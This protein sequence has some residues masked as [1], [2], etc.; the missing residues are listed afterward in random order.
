[1]LQ[2]QD[3]STTKLV[4]LVLLT[5]TACM[6]APKGSGGGAG[7][8]D[9]APVADAAP[10]A[11]AAPIVPACPEGVLAPSGSCY[12]PSDPDLANG[13]NYAAATLACAEQGAHLA[14]IRT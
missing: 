1:M 5:A 13:A 9:A 3:M 12:F 11:D 6:D 2:T 14:V 8:A 4:T 7:S 10:R